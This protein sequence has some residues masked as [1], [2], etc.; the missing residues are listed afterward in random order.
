MTWLQSCCFVDL[1]AVVH[2]LTVLL[3]II[4]VSTFLLFSSPGL[5]FGQKKN[6]Q[7]AGA[8]TARLCSSST[9]GFQALCRS[10]LQKGHLLPPPNPAIRH[11]ACTLTP[12]LPVPRCSGAAGDDAQCLQ[13]HRECCCYQPSCFNK[14]EGRKRSFPLLF[15]TGCVSLS[16]S[17]SAIL[18]LCQG[19]GFSCCTAITYLD[20]DTFLSRLLPLL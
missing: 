19:C 14:W 1:W 8:E 17:L 9:T 11:P 15:N 6:G 7:K 16:L 20:R 3:C 10:G 18:E 12:A 13:R 5:R 2:V 4:S